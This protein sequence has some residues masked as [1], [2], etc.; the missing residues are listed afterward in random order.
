MHY[1]HILP[2]EPSQRSAPTVI[3]LPKN[4]LCEKDNKFVAELVRYIGTINGRETIK[5]SIHDSFESRYKISLRNPP[6]LTL[7]DIRQIEMM[8]SKIL[9]I[10]FDFNRSMIIIEAWKDGRE[11]T[12]NKRDRIDDECFYELPTAIN[13]DTVDESDKPQVG[14]VLKVLVNLT[15]LQ[16]NLDI[17]KNTRVYNLIVSKVETLSINTIDVILNKFRAFVSD[18]T[19]DFPQKNIIFVIRK[20]ESPLQKVAQIRRKKVKIFK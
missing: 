7:D 5:I 13:M 2:M 4:N 8:N 1:L 16:F 6:R 17:T 12:G 19:F 3:S 10:E 14:G 20:T 9:K 15:E 11:L 18:V